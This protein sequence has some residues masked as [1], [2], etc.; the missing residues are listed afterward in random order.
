MASFGY[1]VPELPGRTSPTALP[2]LPDLPPPLPEVDLVEGVLSAI[3]EALALDLEE[4]G[5]IDLAECYI[6]TA[7][8]W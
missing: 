6:E 1:F 4:R 3:L 5:E 8:S 7:P 2:A